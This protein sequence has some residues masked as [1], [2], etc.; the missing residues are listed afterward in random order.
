VGPE[1]VKLLAFQNHLL[2]NAADFDRLEADCILAG[3]EILTDLFD[4]E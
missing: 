2:S 1:L 3:L 4:F